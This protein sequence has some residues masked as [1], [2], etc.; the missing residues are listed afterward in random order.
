[1]LIALWAAV[2]PF[3]ALSAAQAAPLAW[4]IPSMERVKPDSPAGTASEFTLYA[5]KGEYESFQIVV[6]APSGGLTRVSVS[7]PDLGGPRV[8]LYREHFVYLT[9]GSSDWS[10]N[11]NKPLGP[12]WYPD[13]L[14]P[15]V[16]PGTGRDLTGAA[17]DAV[18]FNLAANRNQPIW[19]DVY[20]PRTVP[21]GQY[22]GTF[23]VT[24]DQG[25]ATVALSLTVWNFTLP[26]KPALKSCFL[27]WILHDEAQ[28][29]EELLR[30]RLMPSSVNTSQER[31]LIDNLGLNSTGLGFWAMA[32]KGSGTANPPPSVAK[33]EE[34][35]SEHQQDLLFY[36]YTM[37][38]IYGSTGLY[39]DVR[40]WA[41]NLH[42]AGVNQLI[43]IPPVTSLMDDGSGTGRSAVDLWVELPKQY[44]AAKVAQV[45]AKGDEVWSYNCLQQDD[46][47]PKWLLDY[48]PINYRIQPGF[49]N[50]SLNMTGL[51]YWSLDRWSED[52]WDDA[53][54]YAPNFPGEGMLVYPAG[55]VGLTGVV[56][57]MRLKYLRDGVDDYD[58]IDLLRQHGLG[59]W[60]VTI[61][62]TV[63]PDWENW[64]RDPAALEE[65][66]RQLGQRLSELG[67]SA[68][69]VTVTAAAAPREVLS[70]GT[71]ILSADATDSE[72]HPIIGWH[73]SDG[74][75][76]GSFTPSADVQAPS[77]T[78][79]L[80]TGE[81]D[82]V[83]YLTVTAS[84]GTAAGSASVALTVRAGLTAFL[85]I[86]PDHWAYQEIMACVE[87]G[88]ITGYPDNLYRPGFAVTRAQMAAYISRALA[89]G[90]AEIPEATGEPGFPDVPS[91]GWA[92]KYV[93]YAAAA[94]I[95]TG[96]NDGLY[97]PD[98]TITRGQMAVFIARAMVDPTG[99][100]GLS[101][102]TPPASPTF[103]DVSPTY[104]AYK[105]IEFIAG[106][107]VA[108][109]YPDG[110][111]R[112]GGT[113]TRDQMAV[114]IARAFELV[115]GA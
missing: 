95:V 106:A 89:G 15:F 104:W 111:Y 73:W 28:P 37:D 16:D 112:P 10:S 47:S 2:L 87:A 43:T 30:H 25:Q 99:E 75:A 81:D 11:R 59:D 31:F 48:A 80:N 110:A 23:V 105:H 63:G 45:L 60:A 93:E 62:R 98:W 100:E 35:R 24:S 8:T 61:A 97:H 64:R 55:Q 79:P 32:D 53:E 78:A 69:L 22:R 101:G 39:D 9:R 65:A 3:L 85:D 96:F 107:G 1:V 56:A 7:A 18:P 71:T 44:D 83:V 21:A 91:D 113:C 57:A 27:Y 52:P 74:G 20:V 86:P 77:Y 34:A 33:I 58:Y 67:G 40:A 42:A 41:R 92:A 14:I 46:Y 4:V 108:T 82:I 94:N 76:G 50:Q 102:Y 84:C 38:E 90:D 19:V 66:R 109:G 36:N 103:V 17:L 72:W 51:L 88:V 115:P 26:V 5:A 114:Y 6:R 70:G 49:V 29:A 54:A 68:H 13:G 12:G